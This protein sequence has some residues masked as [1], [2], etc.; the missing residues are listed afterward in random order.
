MADEKEAV[1]QAEGDRGNGEE[2]HRSDSF[3]VVAKKGF[4]ALG[5]VWVPL[6]PVHPARDGSFGSI[7]AEHEE[8][9]VDARSSPGRV[10]GHH[11]EDQIANFLGYG[12]SSEGLPDLGDQHPVPMETSAVPA[13]HGFGCDNQECLFPAGPAAASDQPEEPVE[14]LEP[15]AWM[16][17]FQHR[18]LLA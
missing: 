18:K 7:E 2:I 13:D 6:G 5:K 4:L 11:L 10:V 9:A 3:L 14:E 8:F 1:K 17:A 12:S 15:R 16:T